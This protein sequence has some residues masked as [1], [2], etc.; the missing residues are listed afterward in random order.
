[1]HVRRHVVV[2]SF[3]I[4]LVSLIPQQ[5]S[6]GGVAGGAGKLDSTFS[7]DGRVVTNIGDHDTGNGVVVQPDGK[8]VVA[9][10]AEMTGSLFNWDVVVLKYKRDGSLDP[11]FG[12]GDG[13]VTTDLG[14]PEAPEYQDLGQDVVLQ[15]D[16][17]IVVVGSSTFGEDQ[18]D[19]LVIR[20]K[21]DGTLDSSFGG[22]GI[23]TT[24]ILNA[25]SALG[26][27]LQPDGKF[28]V[29]GSA[30]DDGPP[31]FALLRYEADGD[32]D[33][34]FGD[35]GIT[36]TA[37]GE[38]ENPGAKGEDVALQENGKI[39][40]SGS[41]TRMVVPFPG[42]P[43]APAPG[44]ALL[45]Y[46]ADG[47]LDA[48]FAG[49]GK[50]A[51]ELSITDT[52]RAVEVQPD[53]KIV[54]AGTM[55]DTESSTAVIVRVG[56]AGNLDPSFSSNGIAAIPALDSSHAAGLGIQPNGKVVIGG[57]ATDFDNGSKTFFMAARVTPTG[58]LDSSF[59]GDG[60]ALTLFGDDFVDSALAL[61]LQVDGRIVLAGSALHDPVG[62]LGPDFVL[63]RYLGDAAVTP[64]LVR[65]NAWRL[66]NDFDSDG[67][68]PWFNF[69]VSTDR[70][71][72]GDW[73]GDDDGDPGVVRGNRWFLSYEAPS[74]GNLSFSFASASDRPVPGDWDGNGTWTPAAVRGNVWYV[75]N[76]NPPTSI[77]HSFAFASA[78]DR[79]VAGD[80]D[81]NGT[82]TPGV[83]R[84]NTWYVSN[85]MPPQTVE[86]FQFGKA[87][88]FPVVGD[89]D[90]DGAWTP[91]VVR[92]NVWYLTN[93][94]APQSIYASFVFG[95]MTDRFVVGNWDVL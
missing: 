46:D 65:G 83:V 47:F 86:A 9:G 23:V 42:D 18:A 32:L 27:V 80:W 3:A 11:A 89:W 94:I 4:C 74:T 22:D 40:V 57:S 26:V 34:G 92:G 43:P 38:A 8:T 91:G 71:I 17:K 20:Y 58:I 13:I 75:T 79:P 76:A 66:S 93:E 90:G 2:L 14:S 30:A 64:G 60:R 56:G 35:G 84:G 6:A 5:G 44:S 51:L 15:P 45:R 78:S 53:G 70:P 87:T 50:L 95:K 39:V 88:D 31:R 68:I 54:A 25:D 49:D 61:A 16:G 69:G 19:V 82:W 10:F 28:V 67:D 63:A 33:T 21:P 1:M 72:V 48:S 55:T 37:M 24:D 12:G 41:Y 52:L 29:T 7:G 36:T 73:D 81:G 62:A 59:D 85:Q 77:A